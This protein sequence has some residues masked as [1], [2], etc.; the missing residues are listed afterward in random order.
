MG[1]A[2]A[3]GFF[4]DSGTISSTP[5]EAIADIDGDNILEVFLSGGTILKYSQNTGWTAPST[6]MISPLND[7]GRHAAFS[8]IDGDGVLTV[9]TEPRCTH[10]NHPLSS[11]RNPLRHHQVMSI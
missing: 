11:Y 4:V 1:P 5:P 6:A 3:G 8:D 7:C 2:N 10:L 9:A